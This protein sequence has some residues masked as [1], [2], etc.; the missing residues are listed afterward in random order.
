MG[1]ALGASLQDTLSRVIHTENKRFAA[2]M[3][4]D[5]TVC[6]VLRAGLD[7]EEASYRRTRL[8]FEE[9]MQQKRESAQA[10][11]ELKEDQAKLK[12]ARKEQQQAE[13]VVT[14]MVAAKGFSMSMLGHGRKK[15]GT[16]QH[17]KNR[18]EVFDRVRQVAELSPEQTGHWNYFK[19]TWDEEMAEAHGEDWGQLFAEMM[20]QL[21]NDL[22]EGK[23]D[24]LSVFMENEKKRVLGET[25][26][27][28]LPP[29]SIG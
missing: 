24:A 6:Q 27:L 1:G 29:A 10:K 18:F 26:A 28:F 11:L 9:H 23:T 4:D 8:E 14:A 21:L 7:A 3:R 13:A 25:P 20:Q 17:Q 2:R 15:G 22:L 12:K 19:T 16:Q 5:P